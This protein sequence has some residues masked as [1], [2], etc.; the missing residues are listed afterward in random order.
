ML[1]DE[2]R[3][4]IEKYL[5]KAESA[6]DD[7]EFNMKHNRYS[8]TSNRIYYSIFYSV[9]ALGYTE[10]FITSKHKQL[11]GWFNKKFIFEEKIF[12]EE[13]TKIYKEA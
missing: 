8:T 4:F 3:I 12:D 5:G 10:N 2:K 13:L 6:L 7:A 1:Q 11:M 9:I